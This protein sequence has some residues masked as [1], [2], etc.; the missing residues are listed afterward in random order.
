MLDH[1]KIQVLNTSKRNYNCLWEKKSLFV[2]NWTSIDNYLYKI[3]QVLNYQ[4]LPNFW[5]VLTM[6][7]KLSKDHIT[8]TSWILK[9]L[10][11]MFPYCPY[12]KFPC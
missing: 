9:K 1:W 10:S 7:M 3:E 8:Y 4:Y 2:K 6:M 5:Q 11:F 12:E